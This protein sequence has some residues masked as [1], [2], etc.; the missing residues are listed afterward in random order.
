M[1]QFIIIFHIIFLFLPLFPCTIGVISGEHTPSGK[2]M[3]WKTR[4]SANT[5]NYPIYN[6][7]GIYAFTGLTHSENE[8]QM[9]GGV[10]T[11]GFGILNALSLDMPGLSGLFNGFMIT[12]AL[13]NFA[14]IPEFEAYLTETNHPQ[15]RLNGN[16][17]V[18]DGLGNAAMYEIGDEIWI[19]YDTTD[20]PDG[21][22][23]R[24][25]FSHFGDGL[26]GRE[27]YARSHVVIDDIYTNHQFTVKNL[28]DIHFRDFS[29]ED[30]TP[31]DIPFDGS[32]NGHFGYI[33]I[34]FSI[35][36][37]GSTAAMAIEGINEVGEMPVMWLST[38]FPAVTPTLPILPVP[39][40]LDMA[41]TAILSQTLKRQLINIP[42]RVYLLNSLHFFKP[43][44]TG[45]WDQLIVFEENIRSEFA[46]LPTG[47][48]FIAAY[49]NW[50]ENAAERSH[51]LME[52]FWSVSD[53]DR[54]IPI[55]L[56]P[57]IS[58]YPNPS[59]GSFQISTELDFSNGYTI[60]VY[61][62]KGQIVHREK[63]DAVKNIREH[64]INLDRTLPAGI[65]ILSVSDDE[66]VANTK[67]VVI[68]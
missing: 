57:M 12:H 56:P 59:V 45:I 62:I 35:C 53:I 43:D 2:P 5:T 21:Y 49:T 60:S 25:N 7:D 36:N 9:W 3:L 54:T 8:E 27:R 26:N 46:Y 10:N 14:T 28:V 48:G 51:S 24:T 64:V 47:E 39:L 11:V 52:S 23:I 17:A 4:D 66:I 65:Y 50:I 38:G 34:R 58:T 30:T 31:Y 63:Q 15:R 55:Y 33:H 32:T 42:N 37:Q 20:A 61:N 6:D 18:I 1:K 19:K 13:Q 68:D 22:V 16:F 44:N 29:A 40:N 67:I 41:N